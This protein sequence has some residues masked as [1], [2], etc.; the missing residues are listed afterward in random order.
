MRLEKPGCGIDWRRYFT[1]PVCV[2]PESLTEAQ[3]FQY[4]GQLDASAQILVSTFDRFQATR[5]VATA[6]RAA[7]V[8]DPSR[9]ILPRVTGNTAVSEEA[10][11]PDNHTAVV[12]TGVFQP[13]APDPGTADEV[14]ARLQTRL[15][16]YHKEP[17]NRLTPIPIPFADWDAVRF[18]F[19]DKETTGFR[20]TFEFAEEGVILPDGTL[21]DELPALLLH[22]R[23]DETSMEL[24]ELDRLMLRAPVTGRF[25]F[26][27]YYIYRWAGDEFQPVG[28]STSGRLL[29]QQP[30]LSTHEND[31][32]DRTRTR[33]FL[34]RV[35]AFEHVD[36]ASVVPI[37]HS[38]LVLQLRYFEAF[39]EH[40]RGSATAEP[41]LRIPNSSHK[42]LSWVIDGVN[43]LLRSWTAYLSVLRWRP[44]DDA[45]AS[46]I[47]EEWKSAFP[48]AERKTSHVK[49]LIPIVNQILGSSLFLESLLYFSSNVYA[50]LL[51]GYT[52]METLRRNEQDPTVRRFPATKDLPPFTPE[53]AA[54]IK[55][56][57]RLRF[58]EDPKFRWV[59]CYAGCPVGKPARVYAPTA[60]EGTAFPENGLTA[61]EVEALHAADAAADALGVPAVA[62]APG[63]R[64]GQAMDLAP[65]STKASG[66]ACF[67]SAA[68]LGVAP[69]HT[70]ADFLLE[71]TRGIHFDRKE[72]GFLDL[73]ALQDGATGQGHPLIA[74]LRADEHQKATHLRRQMDVLSTTMV[75]TDPLAENSLTW[76][77]SKVG[78]APG[79]LPAPADPYRDD[80]TRGRRFPGVLEFDDLMAQGDPSGF[81]AFDIES[82]YLACERMS[83]SGGPR[84]PLPVLLALMETEGVKLF[85]P[86]NRL[87][88][89]VTTATKTLVWEAHARDRDHDLRPPILEDW[90][91]PTAADQRARQ[92]WLSY[93]YGLDRFALPAG[94]EGFN[95]R[96]D[97][98]EESGVFVREA[99]ENLARYIRKRVFSHFHRPPALGDDDDFGVLQIWKRSRRMH[100]AALSVMAGFFRQL[101]LDMHAGR[102]GFNPPDSDWLPA[103][104][105]PPDLVG[106]E[107]E[108]VSVTDTE[109]KDFL[110]YYG[111]I[112]IAYNSNPAT[113]EDFKIGAEAAVPADWPLSLRDFLL[114]EHSRYKEV[115]Q[116]MARFVVGL[117]AYLRLNLMEGMS[118]GEYEE[119]DADATPPADRTWGV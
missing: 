10:K 98:I 85:A 54:L 59:A 37:I 51:A 56:H 79:L 49:A 42:V 2:P 50:P 114:F 28:P 13:G 110:S 111:M 62:E 119:A 89:S 73:H 96:I 112:Y 113:L 9:V 61:Y 43:S 99:G 97:T 115:I 40:F 69:L 1:L 47:P 36:R 68:P 108:K 88:R 60:V 64:P 25:R 5:P 86:I 23:I 34:D 29:V 41:R 78:M 55:Q 53:D 19:A 26:D 82:A 107:G 106:E 22:T 105:S 118:P 80:Q 15:P 35:F 75:D 3:R 57:Q 4:I 16:R 38:S 93:P 92:F 30:R 39:E 100:W 71:L 101:E 66:H 91:V 48:P 63:P 104:S 27:P 102:N 33:V 18:Y 14:E 67:F 46:T 12:E 21:A 103:A 58:V 70:T 7:P 94:D 65:F 83:Q 77:R 52:W 84:L 45:V 116:N 81:D 72:Q 44:E 32:R 17:G 117:D 74:V 31:P 87:V 11:L 109:W 20:E 8:G 95:D 6:V 76:W 90:L 24:G